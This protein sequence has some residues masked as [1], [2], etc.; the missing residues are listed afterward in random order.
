MNPGGVSGAWS[1]TLL[2][3]A[4]AVYVGSAVCWA[5]WNMLRHSGRALAPFSSGK[6]AVALSVALLSGAGVMAVSSDRL[7]AADFSE[8]ASYLLIGGVLWLFAAYARSAW[9]DRAAGQE[10]A[11]VTGRR[12]IELVGRLLSKYLETGDPRCLD[13]ARAALEL[14]AR[15]LQKGRDDEQ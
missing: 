4:I 14:E 5:A 6:L 3:V 15:R 11:G 9:R 7:D 13:E 2:G 8:M 10:T 12:D 1:L